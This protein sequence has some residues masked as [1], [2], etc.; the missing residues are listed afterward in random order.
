MEQDA[1]TQ[2]HEIYFNVIVAHGSGDEPWTAD[3]RSELRRALALLEPLEAS[4]ELG[5]EGVQLMA[6]LCLELGNDER[7]EHLLRA[8]LER[9][10]TAPGLHGD[11]G[12]AYANLEK[13]PDAVSHF[14]TAVLLGVDEPDDQWAMV[15]SQLVDALSECG[16]EDRAETVRRW[17]AA[18]CID[19]KARAWLEDEREHEP[20]ER[21]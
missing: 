12:A 9:F 20:G 1:V 5:P 6:S 15:A 2:A 21:A 3:Q 4:G 14:S 13:W 19:D 16:D 11:L 17:A 18:L 8:G 10:P 7:E